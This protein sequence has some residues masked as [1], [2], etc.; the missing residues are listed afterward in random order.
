LAVDWT[1]T[2]VDGE[3]SQSQGSIP[4]AVGN[5]GNPNETTDEKISGLFDDDSDETEWENEVWEDAT[6]ELYREL[7]QLNAEQGKAWNDADWE[8]YKKL[9]KAKEEKRDAWKDANWKL[10]REREKLKE[11]KRLKERLGEI[12]SIEEGR[13]RRR[14]TEKAATKYDKKI[15]KNSRNKLGFDGFYH[16]KLLGECYIHGVMDGEAMMY[17]NGKG[18]E[19][20]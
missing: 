8:G 5:Q 15:R 17:Q 10:Y 20:R 19:E 7:K 6:R 2:E 14:L 16:Y 18:Q 3:K 12:F 1:S 4:G 13:A 11:E 9:K